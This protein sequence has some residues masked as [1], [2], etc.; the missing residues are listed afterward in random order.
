[1]GSAPCSHLRGEARKR[2]R[3]QCSSLVDWPVY[4]RLAYTMRASKG[5]RNAVLDAWSAKAVRGRTAASGS[6]FLGRPVTRQGERRESA[7][8]GHREAAYSQ[9][10]FVLT[11]QR[12][13]ESSATVAL[14]ILQT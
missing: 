6:W 3:V 2:E 8:P 13:P 4:P 9:P 12:S 1:M 11:S 10:L 7:T 5:Q 14:H